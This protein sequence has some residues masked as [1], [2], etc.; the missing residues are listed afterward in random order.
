MLIKYLFKYISKGTDRI[1]VHIPKPV[2]EHTSADTEQNPNVDEIKNFVDARCICPYEACWRI[3]NFPIHYREPAVQV[4]AVH[5]KDMQL[6]KF[7][8]TQHLKSVVNNP[9]QKK[10]TLAE[11]LFY[12]RNSDDGKHL[13]YLDFPLEFVWVDNEKRWKR[14]RNLNR[15]SIGLLTYMHPAFG[16]VFYLRM[17]LCHRKGCGAFED[18][19]TVNDH[20]HSTYREACLAMGLLGNDKEWL[21]AMEEASATT[22]SSQ[23]RT[24][25]SHILIYCDVADPQKLWKQCWKLMSDDIPLR[26]AASF[27]MSKIYIN[28]TG[29]ESYV[30]YELQILLHQHS[31]SVSDFGLPKIPQH[32]VDDLQNRLIMEE[33]K[34]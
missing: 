4:L 10:T 18:L 24:L 25:F 11:W 9:V 5:L 16:E 2:G 28:S 22:T 21:T 7:C 33:K 20:V 23:L 3:F 32:L 29:L 8:S 27:H 6:V 30:L 13:T 12:N 17:L 1:A 15:P 26:V 34:L 19:M 31:K 14:R